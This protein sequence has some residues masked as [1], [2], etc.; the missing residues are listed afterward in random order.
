MKKPYKL[1]RSPIKRKFRLRRTSPKG[2]L[3]KEADRLFSL[4]IRGRDKV[5]QH[6]LCNKRKLHCAHIFSRRNMNLRWYPDNAIG[7]CFY[8]HLHWAHKEP[9]LFNQFVERNLG[10]ERY[11]KLILKKNIIEKTD[12]KIVVAWLKQE[13]SDEQR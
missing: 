11:S 8:H 3:I 7:L 9:I 4:Y 5:C 1:K 12:V 2:K 13:V 6:P 10:L